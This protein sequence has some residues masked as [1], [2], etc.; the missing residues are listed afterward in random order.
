M[1]LKVCNYGFDNRPRYFFF[2][3]FFFTP[4]DCCYGGNIS[5]NDDPT[6]SNCFDIIN[7]QD[8]LS[9]YLRISF[10][11]H[12]ASRRYWSHKNNTGV[13]HL[14]LTELI[15]NKVLCFTY[16]LQIPRWLA[17]FDR[18]KRTSPFVLSVNC[19]RD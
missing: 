5:H 11:V 9:I 19:Q 10:Q 17:D 4:S 2:S 7:F 6:L 15:T 3:F 1:I 14:P 18:R 13:S 8:I 12:D 16:V